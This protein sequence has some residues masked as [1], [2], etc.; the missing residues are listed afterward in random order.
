MQV[1]PDPAE[2]LP[3]GLEFAHSCHNMFRQVVAKPHGREVCKP[4]GPD[5]K[6]AC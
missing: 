6:N 2:A 4:I 5:S 3:P 1:M